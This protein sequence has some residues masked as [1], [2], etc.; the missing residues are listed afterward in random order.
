VGCVNGLTNNIPRLLRLAIQ[1]MSI[2]PLAVAHAG[3][4]LKLCARLT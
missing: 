4:Q 2:Q 3:T 1:V